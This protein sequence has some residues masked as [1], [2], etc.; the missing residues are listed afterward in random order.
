MKKIQKACMN[1][2][3]QVW[4]EKNSINM[5]CLTDKIKSNEEGTIDKLDEIG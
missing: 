2:I 4:Y 5:I 1:K 3:Q